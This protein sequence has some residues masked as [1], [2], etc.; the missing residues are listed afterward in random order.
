MRNLWIDEKNLR[1]FGVI[2]SGENSFDSAE[3]QY[4][5]QEIREE[6][7]TSLSPRNALQTSA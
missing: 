2:V 3:W 6:M 7:G 4:E 5:K 1:D